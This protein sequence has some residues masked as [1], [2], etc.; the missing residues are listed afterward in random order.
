[1]VSDSQ[2]DTTVSEKIETGLEN[3]S[4]SEPSADS[5]NVPKTTEKATSVTQDQQSLEIPPPASV[6]NI[7]SSQ[8]PIKAP[9]T[10]KD[11]SL[12]PVLSQASVIEQSSV[13]PTS[14]SPSES[15]HNDSSAKPP[16]GRKNKEKWVSIIPDL[17]YSPIKSEKNHE[18]VDNNKKS[19]PSRQRNDR[20]RQNQTA[21]KD[22][23]QQTDSK[24][25]SYQK[26]HKI[27]SEDQKKDKHNQNASTSYTSNQN[28]KSQGQ[29]NLASSPG[30]D[31]NDNSGSSPA[32]SATTAA[33]H[34]NTNAKGATYNQQH[35]QQRSYNNRNNSGFR[36]KNYRSGPRK[37]NYYN[38]YAPTPA[39][40]PEPLPSSDNDE[41]VKSFVRKQ[42]EYYFSIENLLKDLFFRSKMDQDGYVDLNLLASFNRIRSVISSTE[43]IVSSLESSAILEL[44]D[45]R[46]K[47]RLRND[48]EKWILNP[49]PTT[50]N[51][52]PEQISNSKDITSTTPNS[53]IA[54]P[55]S[56]T[57]LT[58]VSPQ[59]K[60][61]DTSSD[62]PEKPKNLVEQKP[63]SIPP[64][65]PTLDGA[66]LTN[67]TDSLNSTTSTQGKPFRRVRPLSGDSGAHVNAFSRS[68]V[69]SPLHKQFEYSNDDDLFE[70]DEDISQI[71]S[72]SHHMNPS[73]V[74]NSS[75]THRRNSKQFSKTK[76]NFN[77]S[78]GED[79]SEWDSTGEADEIDDDILSRL[80]I[81]TQKRTRDRTHYQYDRKAAHEDVN[82]IIKDALVHYEQDL[83]LKS[84]IEVSKNIKVGTVDKEQFEALQNSLQNK[85]NISSYLKSPVFKPEHRRRGRK[86]K[87]KFFPVKESTVSNTVSSSFN[88]SS[89]RSISSSI[90]RSP[91][92]G[93]TVVRPSKRYRDSRQH[94]A[95]A[96]V[97][98]VVGSKQL[99]QEDETGI[100]RNIPMSPNSYTEGGMMSSSVGSTGSYMGSYMEKGTY[101]SEHPSHELLR[102]N[103]FVQHKYHKFHDRALRERSKLGPGL[104][105]E[106]NTLFRFW[107]HFLRDSFN[108]RMYN[109]FK[110][111]AIEDSQ[112]SY[113]YGIEC[114]FRFYSYGLEKKFRMDIFKDFMHQTINDHSNGQYYGLEKLWAYLYYRKDKA[115]RELT[116]LPELQEVLSK[117][118]TIDDFKKVN[119]V[120]QTNGINFEQSSQKLHGQ[121]S[122]KP[123]SGSLK[124][125]LSVIVESGGD[126][127]GQGNKPKGL[128]A[129]L[130]V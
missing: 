120:K 128:G 22:K 108:R 68:S 78:S 75:H 12:W 82:E 112:A 36:N 69:A 25:T 57:D 1:M 58:A 130:G 119:M 102:E 129:A 60:N 42:I 40:L 98:W 110:T 100:L 10:S 5:P 109:E 85:S 52:L 73:H 88:S 111:L 127:V 9:N 39:P 62:I 77:Y 87:A 6:W 89:V 56:K 47:I 94:V 74:R 24:P 64:P 121:K 126:G 54:N 49:N 61:E 122:K 91:F 32:F 33:T 76:D 53:D 50:T 80:L 105:H 83:K 99:L 41:S 55:S 29:S 8:K 114:L 93:P 11:D 104:S 90:G 92:I 72:I 28:N 46:D 84:K 43:T 96:P 51:F 66:S 27:S 30:R 3:L 65:H 44:N 16:A 67:Q 21:T 38:S 115:T 117:F 116:I 123:E 34:N 63:L 7:K 17:Q 31:Q 4:I 48:R 70:F 86:P 19:R 18:K 97:G 79:N 107:S 118:N 113:R 15:T 13:K 106:M 81:V 124:S 20:S 71:P 103:G 2:I 125:G 23:K 37:Y 45:S 95:Q 35:G 59:Q 14:T 26:N 101:H